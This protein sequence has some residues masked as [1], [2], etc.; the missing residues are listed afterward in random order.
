MI[1]RCRFGV[2]AIA[3]LV[4]MVPL[5]ARQAARQSSLIDSAALLNDLKTLS[6]D[7]M[8]G[9][10]VNSPGGEKARTFVVERFKASGVQPFGTSYLEPFT[11]SGRRSNTSTPGVN[12]IGHIDGTRSPRRYIVVS[13]HYDHIG[14]RNRVVFNGADDNASGTAAL[15]AL[16]KYFSTHKLENSLIF[17][18]FDA[19]ESGERGSGAWLN[20]PP[21][22]I[23]SIIADVNMD[24]IGRDPDAKLFAV[25]TKA[26]PVLKPI[27]E[28]VITK[29][30]VKLLF[31]H[32]APGG[33]PDTPEEDWSKSSDHYSFQSAKIPAVYLGDEDFAQHHKAT[34]KFETMSFDFYIGAVE[35]SL[36]TVQSFD[37]HLDEIAKV[38]AGN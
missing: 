22:D 32:E 25:G 5:F 38:R 28:E 23:A 36:L 1:Q 6:A 31:G 35:T 3:I 16:A 13:A 18:A 34:D 24:M 7:N 2:L 12:V 10:L 17:A 37:K 11:F 19:E 21:V 8:E 9:R 26:N 30:P 29:A 27:L 4:T 20:A 15:F 14:V 33:K